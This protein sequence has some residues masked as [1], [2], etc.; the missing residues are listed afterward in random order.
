MDLMD[1]DK[2]EE[3]LEGESGNDIDSVLQARVD[4][5][6]DLEFLRDVPLTISVELGQ[7]EI[8][9]Q[10]LIRF[11][12]GTVIELDKLAGEPL[13]IFVNGRLVSRGEVVVINEK[14]GVRLTDIIDPYQGTKK[15]VNSDI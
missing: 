8:C 5:T 10:D 4:Q 14:F 15:V 6:E 2:E 9:V 12:K 3:H 13:E 1:I 7:S 11:I